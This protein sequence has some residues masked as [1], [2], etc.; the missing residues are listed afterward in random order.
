M[1][2][3]IYL[4]D[5]LGRLKAY[6]IIDFDLSGAGENNRGKETEKSRHDISLSKQREL[7]LQRFKQEKE[8]EGLVKNSESELCSN[9]DDDGLMVSIVVLGCIGGNLIEVS[10][11]F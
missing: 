4:Q 3:Q 6:N 8:L 9:A 2:F 10:N 5:F 11:I 7:K 1:V